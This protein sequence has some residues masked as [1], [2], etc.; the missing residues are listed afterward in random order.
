M[1]QQKCKPK[2]S[3]QFSHHYSLTADFKEHFSCNLKDTSPTFCR[4]STTVL[5]EFYFSE[6]QG[7]LQWKA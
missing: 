4:R 1:Q 2:T 5:P 7:C 6:C 3:L